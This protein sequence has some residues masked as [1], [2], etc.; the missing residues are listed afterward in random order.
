MVRHYFT[1][2]VLL[3]VISSLMT[4]SS[5]TSK[6]AYCPRVFQPLMP[7]KS[8]REDKD[9]N[10]EE[11][12]CVYNGKPVCAPAILYDQ[13]CPNMFGL[14]GVCAELCIR[15]SDCEEGEK[16][17]SNGCGHQCMSTVPVKPGSCDPPLSTSWCH[18]F[19]DHDG[20]CPGE[21]KCC[22]TTCG[23]YC[24]QP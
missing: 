5:T 6:P 13:A 10:E 1:K 22:P 4:C 15:D 7:A 21:K 24:K 2:A 14:S 17:C 3:V 19:C 20:D 18:K 8:C 16:C 9:C 12:C 23:R 11:K